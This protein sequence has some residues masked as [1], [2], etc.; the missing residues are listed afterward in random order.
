MKNAVATRLA[1]GS[2]RVTF[3]YRPPYLG[4]GLL[5]AAAAVAALVWL[6]RRE[7]EEVQGEEP[8]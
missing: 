6:R 4:L 7:L 5:C 8:T 3:R 2:R 1:A